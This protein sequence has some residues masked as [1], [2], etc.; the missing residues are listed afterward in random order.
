MATFYTACK[1]AR[2]AGYT[3]IIA[4]DGKVTEIPTVKTRPIGYSNI[5]WHFA[6]YNGRPIIFICPKGS[7]KYLGF[8]DLITIEGIT[9]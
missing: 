2:K 8:Y 5:G 3:H 7:I 4:R 6:N 1:D 9:S